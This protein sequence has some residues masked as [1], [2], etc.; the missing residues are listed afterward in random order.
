MLVKYWVSLVLIYFS[1]LWTLFFFKW[2]NGKVI[3]RKKLLWY[4][5]YF[6]IIVMINTGNKFYKTICFHWNQWSGAEIKWKQF[7]PLPQIPEITNMY[8]CCFF[9]R[10]RTYLHI[11]RLY[12]MSVKG[13]TPYSD[14]FCGILPFTLK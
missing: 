6:W 4:Q 12:C 1:N 7:L 14:I 9:L 13:F 11:W 3:K 8:V 10:A 2:E 5:C